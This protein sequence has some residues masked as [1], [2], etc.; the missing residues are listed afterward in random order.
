MGGKICIHEQ[1]VADETRHFLFAPLQI[2]RVA[3]VNWSSF[4]NHPACVKR[5]SY[6]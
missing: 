1:A 4:N 6:Q 5:D 3:S 2:H